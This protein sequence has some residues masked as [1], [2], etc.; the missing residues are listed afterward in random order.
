MK[1]KVLALGC[2]MSVVVLFTI[3]QY[4]TARAGAGVSASKIGV[5]SVS[6]ALRDCQ[7]TAKYREKTAA[8]NDKMAL[9]EARLTR[10]VQGLTGE[11]RALRR[12][13][14]DYM[15]RYKELLQKQA[16]LKVLEEYNSQQSGLRDRNWT[17]QLYKEILTVVKDLSEKKALE[18]VLER[19]EPT[20]PVA[21]ADQLMMTLS[22]HKVLYD[23]GCLD[24]TD[25]VIAELN[26][27]DLKFDN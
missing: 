6:R 15:A 2:L 7:A 27:K 5:V 23:G 19:T 18:M 11:I 20:F 12:G 24:I 21:T 9:E 26:K 1:S 22:T 4:G 10:E 25:E 16:E 13:S 3:H 17:E 14:E 8:E